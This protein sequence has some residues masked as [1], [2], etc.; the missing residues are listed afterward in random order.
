[1]PDDS[2]YLGLYT[3]LFD[4]F[5]DK[6]PGYTVKESLADR[7]VL[8]KRVRSEGL[9]FC[10]VTL[11]SLGKHL[12]D[13]F[14]VGSFKPFAHLKRASGRTTPRF[15]GPLFKRVFREDGL[16]LD[17]PCPDSVGHIRQACFFLYK[18]ENGYSPELEKKC[19]DSFVSTDCELGRL[20]LSSPP[21]RPIIWRARR[22]IEAVFAGL[23]PSDIT[24]RPGPGASASGSHKSQRYEPLTLFDQVHQVY[25]YY[26]YFYSGSMHLLDRVNAYRALPRKRFPH[27]KL[28][29][30]PKDSRGPRIICM[31]E[32][33][34]MFLQQGLADK[35]RRCIESHPLTRGRVNFTDQTV[36]QRLATEASIVD[37]LASSATLDM[38][39]ASDRISRSLVADLFHG[40]PLMQRALLALS[41]PA[42]ELPDG[43]V[44]ETNKYAPMGSSLCFPVMSIVHFALGVACIQRDTNI[45]TKALAK[46]FY[47]YG[48]DLIVKSVYADLLFERFPDF[49]LVFN[50]G[51][52]FVVGPFRESCGVDAFLGRNVTPQRLKRRFF[53]DLAPR[54]IIGALSIE[55]HLYERGYYSAAKYLRTVLCHRLDELPFVLSGSRVLGWRRS[56]H[57]DVE[58][59]MLRHRHHRQTQQ[60]ECKARVFTTRAD[61]SMVGGWEQLMRFHSGTL[62]GS[63]ELDGP[64]SRY[65]VR[66]AWVP[67]IALQTN[68]PKKLHDAIDRFVRR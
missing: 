10:T 25:P 45:S 40:L 38:K 4:D 18:L 8:L 5:V 51:K 61:C 1:M 2:N 29:L 64:Y 15:L 33:E 68:R 9:A 16:L 19:V 49:G 53:D 23:D 12:D 3:R 44:L 63:Q 35:M 57:R 66:W 24:P 52:S 28:R 42:T 47:V 14:Q 54:N 37:G 39:E 26:D 62:R 13:A 27:S 31:E 6:V 58:A 43:T 21:L 11:P 59:S 46:D 65:E 50:R 56:A 41:T 48:D 22:I 55:E 60:M 36:N 32:Q 67:V 17:N 34:V 30:V 20:D 7:R